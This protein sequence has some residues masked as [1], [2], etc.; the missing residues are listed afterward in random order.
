MR[1]RLL[2]DN[3][4]ADILAAAIT[5]AEKRDGWRSLTRNRVA[6]VAECSEALVSRYFGTM[7]DLRAAIMKHAIKTK[8]LRIVAQGLA[9]DDP[10]A[11][12]AKPELKSEALK[13]LA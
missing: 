9:A 6:S 13:T 12:R 2:P 4:K 8:N 10:Q 3:R 5:I 7:Q 11:K 1:L